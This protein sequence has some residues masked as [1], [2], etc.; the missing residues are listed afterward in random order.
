MRKVA[1]REKQSKPAAAPCSRPLPPP[2]AQSQIFRL[3]QSK[4]RVQIMLYEQVHTRIEGQIIGFD[5]Y[6]NVVLEGAEV[7]ATDEPN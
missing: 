6:M 3:L 4:A 2:V 5:E 1:T 7:S